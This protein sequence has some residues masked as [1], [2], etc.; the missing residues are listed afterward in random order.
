MTVTNTF[1]HDTEPGASAPGA[2]AP[3]ERATPFVPDVALPSPAASAVS[4]PELLAWADEHAPAI[5]TA[6]A[7]VGV[8]EAAGV[9][10]SLRIPELP[11]VTIGAGARAADGRAG[12][13]QEL[14]VRQ[15]FEVGGQARARR[16]AAD[17][18]RTL[19]LARVDDVRWNVHVEVHRLFV[20]VLLAR[21]RLE[22]AQRFEAFASSM[23]DIAGRQVEAGDTAPLVLLVADADLAATREVVLDARRQFDAYRLQLAAVAG[24]P[25]TAL[26]ELHGELPAIRRAPAIEE[27]EA[28]MRTHRPS[29]RTHELAVRAAHSRSEAARRAS[30]PDPALGLGWEREAGPG[31]EPS[32]NVF[33]LTV[34]VPLP[35]ARLQRAEE[36]V[37]AAEATQAAATRDEHLQLLRAA[38]VDAARALDAASDRVELYETDVIPALA[39]NLELLERAYELGEV[40]IHQ[41]SQTRERLLEATSRHIDARIAWYE[42]AAVL[43]GLVGAEL[44]SAHDQEN[45]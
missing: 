24:W 26:P 21:E 45:P 4:L 23:R 42:T 1:A 10:A 38:L 17:D 3:A 34:D 5:R 40:D 30:T 14:G 11:T 18:A 28:S 31:P 35:V 27:L 33:R 8:A 16:R 43:E 39:S 6:R 9:N 29:L 36:A 7:G 15:A 19:A 37:A 41:V 22:Q 32:A 44:W 13:E 25:T 2:H 20:D 12:F